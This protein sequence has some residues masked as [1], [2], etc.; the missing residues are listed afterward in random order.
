MSEAITFDA[1]V[2]KAQ[3]LVD[4]GLRITLDLPETAL[5]AFAQLIAC[6]RAGQVLHVT[7]DVDESVKPVGKE[8]GK[9]KAMT[10]IRKSE[11]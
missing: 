5:I 3:T 10:T 6:K 11:R 7:I 2:Y 9:I 8:N 4:Q 1:T